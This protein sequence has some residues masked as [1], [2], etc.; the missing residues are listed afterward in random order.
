[1]PYGKAI[2]DKKNDIFMCEFP[3][4]DSSGNAVPCGRWCRD[5]VRHITRH[6][7]I[8]ARE[9][10]K[11]LGLNMSESLMSEE[12]KAKLRKANL[13]YKTFKNLEAGKKYR[14]K[15]GRVTIQNYS[16]SEQTKKRLRTL[17]Q[18]VAKKKK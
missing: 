8:T 17:R 1:M 14:L 2:Y 6:H 13:K 15:K 3:V 9:Y 12:T 4:G 16:R 5:L 10:K 11:M 7:K 18:D